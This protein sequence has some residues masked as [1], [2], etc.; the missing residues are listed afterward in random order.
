MQLAEAFLKTGEIQD[1]LDALNQ[2]L[3]DKPDNEAARRLRIQVLSSLAGE[4]NLKQAIEDFAKLA[5][6]S[7][8]DYQRLSILQERLGNKAAAIEAIAKAREHAPED[9]RLTER[10]LDLLLSQKHYQTALELVQQQSSS[11]RW[12]ER[13]GDILA[14]MGNDG[15][16]NDCYQQ[17]QDKLQAYESVMRPD[18]FHAL[19][20][21]LLLARAHT[22]R[23]LAS[24]DTARQLY[25]S[26]QALLP[27]D[28]TIA[29][30]LGLLELQRGDKAA[31]I[32]QCQD[33]LVSASETLKREMLNSLDDED[34]KAALLKI[35]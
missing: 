8:E 7:A 28:P 6:A 13:E 11:W 1:A 17:A 18:Y 27:K 30:N 34:F 33:A 15:K 29:F 5:T 32:Q 22:E 10:Y 19:K 2:E 4:A 21:R 20:A 25:E 9:E 35:G 3:S 23:R 16:A 24:L 26:A 12:N 14:L 31:A